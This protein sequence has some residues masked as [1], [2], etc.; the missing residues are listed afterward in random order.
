MTTSKKLLSQ[1][2]K[3][4][5]SLEK[6]KTDPLDVHLTEAYKELRTITAEVDSRIDIDEMLNDILGSKITRVQELAKILAAPELYVNRLKDTK[7]RNLGKM[8]VYKHPMKMTRLGY[9]SLERSLERIALH[10]DAMARGDEDDIIPLMSGVPDDYAFASQDSIFL[11]DLDKFAKKIPKNKRVAISKLIEAE[12]FEIFL[13]N[14]LYVVVLI[15][16]GLLQYF[17]DTQ[18]VLKTA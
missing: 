7:P 4:V 2:Q 14:F 17:S 11:S 12:D 8:I 3:I 1:V 6:G 16:R 9:E 13:K 18:E 5:D 15:S 10:I